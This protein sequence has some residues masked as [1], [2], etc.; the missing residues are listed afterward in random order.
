MQTKEKSA[1]DVQG[2]IRDAVETARQH[3]QNNLEPDMVRATEFYNGEPFGDER[4]GRSKVVS[5]DVHDV[6]LGQLPS[7]MRLF[8]GSEDAVEFAPDGPQDIEVARQMTDYVNWAVRE[9]NNGFLEYY[10][11]FKDALVRRVGVFKWWW[12]DFTRVKGSLHTGVDQDGLLAL[13]TDADVIDIQIEGIEVVDGMELATVRV[14]REEKFGYPCFGAIPPEEFIFTPTARSIETAPLVAHVREVAREEVVALGVDVDGLDDALSLDRSVLAQEMSDARLPNGPWVAEDNDLDES[15]DKVLLSEVYALLDVDG[16]GRAEIR[17]F[18]CVGESF[19]ILNGD[20]LGE[21][22]DEVPFA[23]ITPD[24]EP[25]TIVGRSNYDDQREIQRVKSQILRGTLNSLAQAVDPTLI[26]KDGDVNPRDIVN[27]EVSGVIRT[28]GDPNQVLREIGHQFVG[29][30]TLPM[31]EYYDMVREDRSG[32]SRGS[33]ALDPKALQSSTR[34]GVSAAITAAQQ[35]VEMIAR[36]FAETGV[37]RLYAGLLGLAIRYQDRPRVIRIRGEWVPVD[38]RHWHSSLDVQVNLSIGQGSVED[39]MTVLS[40]LAGKQMELLSAGSPLVSWVEVRR[41]MAEILKLAGRKDVDL[42]LKPFGP[43]EQMM[44]EQQMAQ[45]P[46]QPDPAT[47]LAQ[48][49]MQ[50]AQIDMQ[51]AQAQIQLDAQKAQQSAQVDSARLVMDRLRLAMDDD[52]ERDRIARD[53]ALRERELELT[54]RAEINDA[55]LRAAVARDRAAMDADVKVQ[56][57]GG[58]GV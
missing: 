3:H 29:H 15:Q 38:P 51:K 53:M 40:M 1:E 55:E 8:L 43:Q 52:R 44:L 22:V 21:V 41:T 35:R 54:H 13:Y 11:A 12:E 39:R 18:L 10:A 57:G 27:P 37:K 4:E 45:Q 24:P 33:E 7:L 30:A 56:L 46:P 20:G 50:K 23:V 6:T 19:Q 32:W 42:L 48:I 47:M 17:K 5:M 36:S 9:A 16:D 28:L 34:T 25:H 31:L 2:I 14:L 49:E 26:V 58:S